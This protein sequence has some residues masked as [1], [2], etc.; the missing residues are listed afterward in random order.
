MITKLSL[1]YRFAVAFISLVLVSIHI[2][3]DH[4]HGGV[5]THYLLHDKDLPGF[6]NWWSLV[7]IPLMTWL[8]LYFT[9]Q[10]L[11]RVGGEKNV[12]IWGRFIAGLLFGVIL[13]VSFMAGNETLPAGMMLGAIALSF[14][15]PLF[16]ADYFLGFLIGMEYV[17]GGV[18]P[19]IVI[20]ILLSVF[21][22]AYIIKKAVVYLFTKVNS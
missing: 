16:R 12:T 4:F 9:N 15:V 2:I 5:P 11:K 8:L 10:R 1:R 7:T 17:F 22:L 14:I 6:T 13:S 20:L 19:I 21:H 18:L 3:W